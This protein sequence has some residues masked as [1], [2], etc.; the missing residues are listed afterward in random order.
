MTR[1]T[2][3]D[4]P[5]SATMVSERGARLL[6]GSGLLLLAMLWLGPLPEMARRA[7][8]PHMV[9]H[10]GVTVVAAPLI[11]LGLI[12]LSRDRAV[13]HPVA[14]ALGASL[15]EMLVVWGWHAPVLHEAAAA[16][17]PAFVAQ[18]ASFFCAGLL[19]WVTALAGRSR[20][21]AGVSVFAM[22]FTFMHMAML[23]LLLSL[24]PGLLY[25]PAYCLGAWGFDPLDDQRLGG[26]LMAV[27]GG[28]P[29]LAG[30]LAL[31]WRMLDD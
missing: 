14:W 17:L 27:L 1:Q 5:V 11:A 15:F 31:T 19:I 20:A 3:A 12:G 25:D 2:R 23:G 29:Y 13:R 16:R 22:L 18:Q 26:A 6:L 21:M 30:G 24:A 8:S 10:L 4:H 28:L 7:F 9:L